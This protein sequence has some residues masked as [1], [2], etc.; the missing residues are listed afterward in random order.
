VATKQELISG[1]EFLIGESRRIAA[2]LSDDD[3][4]KAVDQDGWTGAQVLAHVAGIGTVI[5]QFINAI[6]NAPAGTDA[7][8]G[9]GNID[10]MNAGLVGARAGKTPRELAEEVATA[11]TS[12]IEFVRGVP[13][14]FLEKHGTA[15]GHKDVP[16]GDLMMRMV[17][18]HGLAHIYS[19]YS[20]VFFG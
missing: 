17:I 11:Y 16:L 9:T 8:G 19:V 6:A 10:A 13:D 1:L 2:G 14:D 3:W 12:V 5:P 20:S 18:L 15:A 7:M 4:A